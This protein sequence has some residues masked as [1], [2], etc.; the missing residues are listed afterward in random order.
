MTLAENLPKDANPE[1]YTFVSSRHYYRKEKIING[2][3]GLSGIVGQPGPIAGV[4]IN[5]F[6][7]IVNVIAKIM[8]FLLRITEYAFDVVHNF[9]FG[10][11]D[12]LLPNSII[13]GK[14]LTYKYPRYIMTVLLP[15]IGV[16]MSKGA[17]GFFNVFVCLIITYV[18][19]FAGIIYAFV[20][21]LRSRY[22]DQY[23]QHEYATLKTRNPD[24]TIMPSDSNAFSG[25]IG[26]IIIMTLTIAFFF[27]YF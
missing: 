5:V 3:G 17:Y 11:F 26:F 4:V 16:F 15:P 14:V 13:G 18:N 27:Y 1:D 2:Q 25:L 8:V 19:Y 23:E 7:L 6:D 24:V 10:N 12:G 20:I 9:A 22:A 21:T